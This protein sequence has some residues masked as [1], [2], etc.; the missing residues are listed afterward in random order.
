MATVTESIWTRQ[1]SSS[2]RSHAAEIRICSAFALQASLSPPCPP[3]P[4][5]LLRSAA[6]NT[7]W[8]RR[9]VMT[10]DRTKPRIHDPSSH[11]VIKAPR[12]QNFQSWV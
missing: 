4:C 8:L 12:S 5:P 7:Q 2:P 6:R 1:P 9:N 3:L 10:T 11:S